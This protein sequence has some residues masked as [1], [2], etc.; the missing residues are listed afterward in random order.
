MRGSGRR[1]GQARVC[2]P[3]QDAPQCPKTFLL[4]RKNEGAALH[5]QIGCQ[6]PSNQRVF[7]WLDDT[8]R[9]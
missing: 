8:L 1:R 7:D 4:F 5:C 9:A 2:G 3:I 6:L